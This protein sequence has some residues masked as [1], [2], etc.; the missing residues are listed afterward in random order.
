MRYSAILYYSTLYSNV[1][2]YITLNPETPGIQI[3]S[4]SSTDLKRE[5]NPGLLQGT[6]PS[7]RLL[8]GAIADGMRDIL[9]CFSV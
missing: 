2:Y 7:G 4:W 6:T 3:P 8:D 9:L 5:H 1:L